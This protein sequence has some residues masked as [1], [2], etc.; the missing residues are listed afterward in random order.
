MKDVFLWQKL[1]H[2]QIA[3]LNAETIFARPLSIVSSF[4]NILPDLIVRHRITN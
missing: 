4:F 2:L 3:N 1:K